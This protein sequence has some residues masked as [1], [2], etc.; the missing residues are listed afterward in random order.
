MHYAKEENG[1]WIEVQ[2]NGVKAEILAK[3]GFF[4]LIKNEE[5]VGENQQ[6]V[7]VKDG[8]VCREEVITYEH[9][10]KFGSLNPSAIDNK[11]KDF[12]AK[13]FAQREDKTEQG[14]TEVRTWK[15]VASDLKTLRKLAWGRWKEHVNDYIETKFAPDDENS[16]AGI[17]LA[18]LVLVGFFGS[19]WP[20]QTS[21]G[22]RPLSAGEITQIKQDVKAEL[23][24]KRQ[25]VETACMPAANNAPAYLAAL[26]ASEAWV[27]RGEL[28]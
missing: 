23:K 26:K 27:E 1:R 24:A 22:R 5:A 19:D 6:V 20:I 16:A 13:H 10:V 11:L 3:L 28:P 8:D 7:I 9:F 21:T 18:D 17:S 15:L 2:G 4:Q 25:Q 12:L 14:N